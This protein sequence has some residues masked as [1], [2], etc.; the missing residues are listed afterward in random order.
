MSRIVVVLIALWCSASG[1]NA[2]DLTAQ[3]QKIVRT[4]LA[5]DGWLTEADHRTFWADVPTSV[6]SDPAAMSKFAQELVRHSAA[7]AR[8]Q[9]AVWESLAQTVTAK[10][11]MRSSAY[12]LERV[13]MVKALGD[14]GVENA[15]KAE[16]MFQ[17][18]ASG[19]PFSG[20]DG[21]FYITKELVD[22]TLGGLEG[23]LHRAS[24][25]ENPVWQD[26]PRERAYPSEHV[27]VLWDGPF[28]RKTETVTTPSGVPLSLVMLDY[29]VSETDHLA[30]VYA[31]L[32]MPWSDPSTGIT[33]M[34]TDSL[35]GMGVTP[36][37]LWTSQWRGRLSAEATGSATTASG[38]IHA[39]VRFVEGRELS[40]VWQIMAISG[41][42]LPDAIRLRDALEASIQ[43]G[44]RQ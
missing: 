37:G 25:L 27:R 33:K 11:V 43:L 18:A 15:K 34:V 8:F 9:R 17:A 36:V 30:I 13:E 22:Q 39:A 2:Q 6:K 20:P 28:S 32:P 40:S 23:S 5:A 19:K 35:K 14:R 38:Q 10:Q 12:E 7:A 44:P 41:S 31:R 24:K 26:R 1:G 29:R 3:Q 4:A 16:A 42:S 21:Q